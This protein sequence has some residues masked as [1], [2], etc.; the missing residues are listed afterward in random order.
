MG[1]ITDRPTL[2]ALLGSSDEKNVRTALN[3]LSALGDPVV[4][5]EASRIFNTTKNEAMKNTA[6]QI[7]LN[8]RSDEATAA[9]GWKTTTYNMA[10]RSAA[11]NWYAS[12][13]PAKARKMALDAVTNFA[14][15]PVRMAAIRVLGQVK[16]EPGKREVFEILIGLAK[17]RPYAPMQ[18]AINALADYGD[19]A[20]IPVIESRKDHSLHFA[21]GTV[22][23]ALARLGR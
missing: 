14:P 16:D 8:L 23:G 1:H 13:Q 10:T 12:H 15:G 19:K 18:A 9:M 7:L 4:A 21:R 2:V 5:Q 20:A 3:Q 17:G 11:L 6:Y 22:A